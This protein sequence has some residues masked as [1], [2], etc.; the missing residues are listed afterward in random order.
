MYMQIIYNSMYTSRIGEQNAKAFK[1][2]QVGTY[3]KISED[4]D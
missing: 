1:R 2:I 3:T 4:W